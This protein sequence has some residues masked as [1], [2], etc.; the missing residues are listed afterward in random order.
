MTQTENRKSSGTGALTEP[1]SSPS[2]L[3]FLLSRF[4]DRTAFEVV[5]WAR[6]N[7]R[8]V[9]GEMDLSRWPPLPKTSTESPVGSPKG[10]A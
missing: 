1:V 10:K 6:S 2:N 5:T 8:R 9:L 3:S 4:K 7:R